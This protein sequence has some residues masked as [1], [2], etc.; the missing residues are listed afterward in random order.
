MNKILIGW[1]G[2]RS[3]PLC[4]VAKV[5]ENAAEYNRHQS[6]LI[7]RLRCATFIES[8]VFLLLL[9]VLVQ[10]LAVPSVILPLLLRRLFLLAIFTSNNLFWPWIPLWLCEC[11][12]K[13][14]WSRFFFFTCNLIFSHIEICVCFYRVVTASWFAVKVVFSVCCILQF[15]VDFCATQWLRWFRLRTGVSICLSG[16]DNE[17]WSTFQVCDSSVSLNLQ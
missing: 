12:R 5:F 9:F 15:V 16:Y 3:L 6:R 8:R 17:F 1:R 10:L 14:V 11:F 4:T 13:G 7:S 2:T